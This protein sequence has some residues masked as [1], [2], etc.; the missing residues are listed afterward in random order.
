MVDNNLSFIIKVYNIIRTK[1]LNGELNDFDVVNNL[2]SS[3]SNKL[4]KKKYISYCNRIK[5]S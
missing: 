4:I 1:Y 2:G 3:Y 5:K